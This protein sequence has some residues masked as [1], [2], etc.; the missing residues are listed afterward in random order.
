MALWKW[1]QVFKLEMLTADS[2]NRINQQRIQLIS[3]I[4]STFKEKFEPFKQ[5]IGKSNTGFNDETLNMAETLTRGGPFH[6]LLEKYHQLAGDFNDV[7]NQIVQS[8]YA[9]DNIAAQTHNSL[10]EGAQKFGFIYM[11]Q[12]FPVVSAMSQRLVKTATVD[13]EYS[14]PTLPKKAKFQILY[15]RIMRNFQECWLLF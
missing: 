6:D 10:I 1:L 14:A 15:R 2:Q 3:H 5:Y 7:N 13:F 8:F 9:N 11:P 4:I 12:H